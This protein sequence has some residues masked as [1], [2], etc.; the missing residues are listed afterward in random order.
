MNHLKTYALISLT[1]SWFSVGTKQKKYDDKNNDG[2]IGVININMNKLKTRGG[3]YLRYDDNMDNEMHYP[4]DKTAVTQPTQRISSQE[5]LILNDDDVLGQGARYVLLPGDSVRITENPSDKMLKFTSNNDI[6]NNELEF[7]NALKN[8]LQNFNYYKMAQAIKFGGAKNQVLKEI[9]IYYKSADYKFAAN[10][11][12]TKYNDQLAFLKSY[13]SAHPMSAKMTEIFAD[14]LY[15]D[16]TTFRFMIASNMAKRNLPPDDKFINDIQTFQQK[17]SNGN[18]QYISNYRSSLRDY[19][20][21][22]NITANPKKIPIYNLISQNFDSHAKDYL[23]FYTVKKYIGAKKASAQMLDDFYK[24]CQNI[25]YSAEIKRLSGFAN[26]ETQASLA[27]NT[28]ATTTFDAIKEECKL[29]ETVLYI[30]FWASWCVPCMKQMPYAAKLREDLKELPIRF[31]YF[32]M[33]NSFASWQASSKLLKHNSADNFLV[34]NNFHSPLASTFNLTTIPRYVIINKAG[35]IV[36]VKDND[37]APSA[38]G[39]KKLLRDLANQDIAATS[40]VKTN[41]PQGK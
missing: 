40:P 35:D 32:S 12:T 30:D 31:V 10:Y 20:T 19:T 24:D 23:L 39:I 7:F 16:Y 2:N 27:D 33:D 8:N 29:K 13:T 1:L 41:R 38:G 22:L 14:I 15:F 21:Y 18:Y 3:L 26:H 28:G 25:T 4:Y 6:R 37:S 17:I 36:P 34:A 5:P 11:T 9:F